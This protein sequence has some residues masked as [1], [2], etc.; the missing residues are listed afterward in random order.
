MAECQVGV[1]ECQVGM[2]VCQVGV[3]MSVRWVCTDGCG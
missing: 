3:W 1:D 2:D